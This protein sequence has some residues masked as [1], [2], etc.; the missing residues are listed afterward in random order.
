MTKFTVTDDTGKSISVYA[1]LIKDTG[2]LINYEN[3]KG[4][5]KKIKYEIGMQ[6]SGDSFVEEVVKQ[7]NQMSKSENGAKVLSHLVKSKNTFDYKNKYRLDSKGNVVNKD[8][9]QFKPYEKGGG[10]VRV[11]FIMNSNVG[12]LD[13]L[14][15]LTHESYHAYQSEFGFNNSNDISTEVEAYLYA[16]TVTWQTMKQMKTFGRIKNK[17]IAQMYYDMSIDELLRNGYDQVTYEAAINNFLQ[18]SEAN[19]FGHY[20]SLQKHIKV[21]LLSLHKFNLKVK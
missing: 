9:A 2:I 16:A 13:K 18:G 21:P 4:Y 3:S 1:S 14:D 10:V 8:S 20:N 19:K 6:Y 17:N 15:G 12:S 5:L 11:G 7:L